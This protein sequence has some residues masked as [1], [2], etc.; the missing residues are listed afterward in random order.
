MDV[1]NSF[2]DF[3]E[4]KDKHGMVDSWCGEQFDAKNRVLLLRKWIK[5]ASNLP[6]ISTVVSADTVNI[7][8]RKGAQSAGLFDD[9]T[10]MMLNV[11][12]E[13]ECKKC[14][15][16]FCRHIKEESRQ[17]V[18]NNLT[19][20]GYCHLRVD[21]VSHNKTFD[22]FQLVNVNEFFMFF[23][24]WNNEPVLKA[25]SLRYDEKITPEGNMLDDINVNMFGGRNFEKSFFINGLLNDVDGEPALEATFFVSR[26]VEGKLSAEGNTPA[27]IG[28]ASSGLAYTRKYN[29]ETAE[30]LLP[31]IFYNGFEAARL[32]VWCDNGVIKKGYPAA[33][34]S[35]EPYSETF[36]DDADVVNFFVFTE[37]Q[38]R[39]LVYDNNVNVVLQGNVK[40]SVGSPAVFLPDG[41]KEWWV[42]DKYLFSEPF[43]ASYD[44]DSFLVKPVVEK[45]V[46]EFTV[47]DVGMCGKVPESLEGKI[48][49]DLSHIFNTHKLRTY[50]GETFD[51]IFKTVAVEGFFTETTSYA[52]N[53]KETLT[54]KIVDIVGEDVFYL[55]T[56]THKDDVMTDFTE[57]S[58]KNTMLYDFHGTPA[59]N[60]SDSKI[61][62]GRE[63]VNVNVPVAVLDVYCAG[64]SWYSELK[65]F[66]EPFM[67][68]VKKHA[69]TVFFGSVLSQN[70]ALRGTILASFY[71]EAKKLEA[72][73]YASGVEKYFVYKNFNNVSCETLLY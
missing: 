10:R 65:P 44:A 25:Y 69:Y 47:N 68:Q 70:V 12:E 15:R 53:L 54:V 31:L 19:T 1:F 46:L 11:S 41:V 33:A 62:V 72:A 43:D 50:S 32:A 24:T 59:V 23:T 30:I 22:G 28:S 18:V 17:N 20:H 71:D 64:L 45:N 9:M 26:W 56:V 16:V 48:F 52:F 57:L 29:E 40:H 73:V 63:D 2:T 66:V 55:V 36:Y 3:Y 42:D 14:D 51:V 7:F 39:K 60:M 58:F 61:W 49:S 5:I 67:K 27:F 21:N 8:A 4:L 35:R 37:G 34:V 38:K 6:K 13:Q